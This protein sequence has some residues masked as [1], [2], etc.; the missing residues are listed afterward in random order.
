MLALGSQHSQLANQVLNLPGSAD[1]YN[2][3]ARIYLAK[4]IAALGSRKSIND[5]LFV[6]SN[7]RGTNDYFINVLTK[8]RGIYK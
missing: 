5:L 7:L 8:A 3:T 4:Q 2:K 6:K 1:G